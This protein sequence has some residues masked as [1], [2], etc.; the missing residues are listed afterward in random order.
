MT[1]EPASKRG[2]AARGRVVAPAEGERRALRN[3]TAQYRVAAK[4]VRDALLDG[5]FEWVRLLDPDAG[6]L[7]DVQIARPGRL[8]A[9]QVK[10]S[11]Y[12]GQISFKALVSETSVSGKPY[13]APFKLLADGWT[14]LQAAHPTRLVRAHYL[15]HDA[16]S[17][18]YLPKVEGEGDPPHLQGFLRHAWPL[19]AHW[20]ADANADLRAQWHLKIDAIRDCTGL[21]GE[22]FDRFLALCELDLAFEVQD[23]SGS[24]AERREC[25]IEELGHFLMQRAAASRDAL[26]LT[27]ETLLR[28]LGWTSRFE[29]SFRHEFPVDERLYRPVVET[30]S[31]IQQALANHDRGYIALVGPPGS[32]KSTALTHTLRY[33]RGIR[34]VRY[35]AYVRDDLRQGRGEAETFLHDLCLSLAPLAPRAGRGD[36]VDNLEGLKA[37]LGELFGA[38]HGEWKATGIKTVILIDGLDHIER[39]QSPDRSLIHDLPHPTSVPAGIIV[40]LGTQRVGLESKVATLRP[41]NTQLAEPSRT[42]EMAP[43]SRASIRSIVAVGVPS[44]IVSPEILERIEHLS[45][46]HPLALAYLVKRLSGITEIAACERALDE[47]AAY[48]GE[49]EQD[50]QKCWDTLRDEPNVRDLLG[51]IS[52]LRG[53]IDLSTIE[54]LADH[55]VIE[56]FVATAQHYFH[57]DSA[58][59]WRFFHNSFRQFVL[60]NTGLNAFGRPDATR[61]TAYH[62]RLADAAAKGTSY[63]PLA[64]EQIF[65]LEKAGA[66]AEILA[67]DHQPFFR[68]HFLQGRP[69]EDIEEDIHLC[70]TTAAAAGGALLVFRHL[71]AEKELGDRTSSL[72]QVDLATMALKLAAPEDRPTALMSATA[73]LVPD[74]VALEWAGRLAVSGNFTL[75]S[76]LFDMAEPLDLLSGVERLAASG[77]D[78]DLDA[79][80]AVAWRFRPLETIVQATLQ[81]RV[82]VSFPDL[83]PPHEAASKANTRARAHLLTELALALLDAGETDSLTALQTLLATV[84]GLR[85]LPLRLDVE[86]VRRAILK[87]EELDVGPAALTRVIK[88]APPPKLG[89]KDCAE[90]ADLICGLRHQTERADAYLD[91][92]ATPLVR[93]SIGSMQGNAFETA[94]PLLRQAR[95]SAARGRPMDSAVSVPPATR[96]HARGWVLFQRA[97]VRLGTLWGEA[98]RG[99]TLPPT[100]VVRRLGPEIRFYRRSWRETMRWT[101]WH[102]IQASSDRFL[103]GVLGAALAHGHDAYQATLE[104]M[105]SDWQRLDRGTGQWTIRQKRA[106]AMTAYG[107]DGDAART[108]RILTDLDSSLNITYEVHERIEEHQAAFDAWLDLG[109]VKRARRAHDQMLATS[110]SLY[111]DRDGQIF[112]WSRWA[113]RAIEQTDGVERARIAELILGIVAILHKNHRGDGRGDAVRTILRVLSR[114]DP[115]AALRAADWLLDDAAALRSDVFAGILAGQLESTDPDVLANALI[116]GCRLLLPF[117]LHAD[118]DL[119]KAVE[120]VAAAPL[121]THAR[122]ASALETYRLVVRTKVQHPIVYET[123]LRLPPRVYL[124]PKERALPTLTLAD[125][126]ALYQE[127]VERLAARPDALLR[128]LQ[129]AVDTGIGWTRVLAALPRPLEKKTFAPIG[130]WLVDAGVGPVRLG[131]VVRCAIEAADPSLAKAAAEAAL[132]RSKPSGWLCRFDGGTRKAAAESLVLVDPLQGKRRALKLLVDDHIE[133]PLAVR[134]LIAE[135]DKLM[136]LLSEDLDA[137]AIWSEL[138]QHI[139]AIAEAVEDDTHVP[140]LEGLEPLAAGEIS[141]RLLCADLRNLS[142]IVVIEA[143]KGVIAQLKQGDPGGFAMRGLMA[144]LAGNHDDRTTALA[145]ISCLAWSDPALARVFLGAIRPFVWDQ[146]AVLRRMAQQIFI[147]LDEAEVKAPAARDLPPLYRLKLPD[148]PMRQ[149]TL[150]GGALAPGEP[151]PDTEDGVDL[152]RLFHEPLEYIASETGFT[153]SLLTQRFAQIMRTVAPV[154][155]WSADAERA[156]IARLEGINM[157]TSVRRLRSLVAWHAFGLLVGEVSDAGQL[158]WPD[159]KLDA[160]LLGVEPDMEMQDPV[161]RPD[162]VTVPTGKEIGAYPKEDWLSGAHAA[163]PTLRYTPDGAVVLAE[164]TSTISM[165]G[166]NEEESRMSVISHAMLPLRRLMPSMQRFGLDKDYV[167]RE[168]PMV[169]GKPPFPSTVIAGGLL[170]CEA[171]FVA[172]NPVLGLHL[173]WDAAE[174]G[175]FR[176]VDAEGNVMAESLW[177]Q[178]GNRSLHERSGMDEA[179]SLGWLVTVSPEGWRQ[180][181]PEIQGFVVHGCA[182]RSTGSEDDDVEGDLLSV[183]VETW[184]L[185]V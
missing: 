131:A 49:I 64:W 169:Y 111:H 38:L 173:G 151:L 150:R 92:I 35:Y 87:R 4:L 164:L 106:I 53:A 154:E 60:A 25:D 108:E 71:L 68:A 132:A 145:T 22:T 122:V 69:Q 84:P 41:I 33:S 167:G 11:D 109:N 175:L 52:R 110:F 103:N 148:A 14:A 21:T 141:V 125:G 44:D 121:A 48:A 115:A 143:R 63:S 18:A 46:G 129:G 40:I 174:D 101:D 127:V 77:E 39:E 6:R 94:M 42:L 89:P 31:A 23:I 113:A 96:D 107:I 43:L 133:R 139:A 153:F 8:D 149:R 135:F 37:R 185:P 83:A 134:D 112:D 13:P 12:R 142:T 178:E 30:V 172:L 67:L 56:R 32:G 3:L 157:K 171:D 58:S 28:D 47:A 120:A 182:G 126:T 144:L 183:H 1:S 10:W 59:R 166:N 138:R 50:Y 91:A 9:Y 36:H 102:Q 24:G 88:A 99:T 51:L 86:R 17:S 170:F 162:W 19:R 95:A 136:P 80:A 73:L 119:A 104:A 76:R 124:P 20:F 165:D 160:W 118:Q 179:A 123:M 163:M 116:A 75:G 82:D 27:R 140:S 85:R 65:H 72:D 158:S 168:Y 177:W 45:A 100:E 62:R 114:L 81:V 54:A 97:M 176:W 74:K 2:G 161:P 155:A 57:Q 34:L 117:E 105:F 184:P 79:W 181:L 130:R 152:S 16:A 90:I 61:A 147:D 137:T 70:M 66:A 15:T 26:T 55:R 7:D 5:D 159:P 146:D 98:L 180:M 93:D 156:V 29:L 128:A 78:D